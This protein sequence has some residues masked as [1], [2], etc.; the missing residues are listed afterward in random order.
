M[1]NVEK[2]K[3]KD[4][5]LLAKYKK[6][7]SWKPYHGYML[8]V[9]IL[10][11]LASTIDEMTSNIQGN[12]QSSIIN[13][14]Y[15]FPTGDALSKA[16]ADFVLITT[17]ASVSSLISPFYKSLADRFGRKFFLWMNVL[18]MSVGML[19][20]FWSPNFVVYLIGYLVMSFFVTHDMQVVYVFEVAP[21]KKRASLYGFTKCLGTLTVILIPLL[22]KAFLTDADPT[23]WR[24]V[25]LIP[26]LLGFAF[27][28]LIFFLAKETNVFLDDRIAYLSRPYEERQKEIADAKAAKDSDKQHKKGVF[29]AIKYIFSK[30]ALRWVAI[31]QIVVGL[32]FAPLSNWYTS[33][34]E[35]FHWSTDQQTNVLMLFSTIYALSMLLAGLI[36]DKLGRKNVI[37][38]CLGF[39]VVFFP[40]FAFGSQYNWNAWAVGVF[41]SLYRS[42]L[43]IAY[44]YLTLM[45][46]EM[47]P[48]ETRGSIMGGQSLCSYLGVAVGLGITSL[49]MI[50]PGLFIGYSCLIVGLPFMA[51]AFGLSIPLLKESKGTDLETVKE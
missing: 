27:A 14:F 41:M 28:A 44:D 15:S 36:G 17:L 13:D 38:G 10:L 35:G 31:V 12:L 50:I 8:I 34:L 43:Y 16:S 37:I 29:P 19:L 18:G 39:A 47:S 4:E 49:V 20:C 25:F 9:I 2:K 46:S 6:R 21:P 26:A 1:E 45:A 7:R 33:I 11:I 24:K 40:L 22:R 51:I 3:E 23:S 30:P 48:T 42:G 5:R 32:G